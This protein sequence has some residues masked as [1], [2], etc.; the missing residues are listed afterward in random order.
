MGYTIPAMLKLMQ[1]HDAKTLFKEEF[2]EKARS[3]AVGR[4]FVQVAPVARWE[5]EVELRYDVGVR[6][7]GVD[8]ARWPEDLRVEIVT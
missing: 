8:A 1:E 2:F 5:K 7:N 3:E 6:G 4:T